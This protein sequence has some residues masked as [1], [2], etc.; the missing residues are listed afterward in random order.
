MAGSEPTHPKMKLPVDKLR[1]QIMSY[2]SCYV[3]LLL[4]EDEKQDIKI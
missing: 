3:A 4:K 1:P 2:H